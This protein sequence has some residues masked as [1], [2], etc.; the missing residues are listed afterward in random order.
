M[1]MNGQPRLSALLLLDLLAQAG[2]TVYYAGDFDP[3]GLLIAWK[4]KRYYG[5]SFCYW[6]MTA[7]NYE[8]SKSQERISDK[9]LKMLSHISDPGLEEILLAMKRDKVA[10]Y[11][12][13]IWK[14]YCG[15]EE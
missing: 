6:Q 12:E 15:G 4:L 3:E 2:I 11:Q 13:T 7:E 10:G 1:C 5:G 9:R 14:K 8:E